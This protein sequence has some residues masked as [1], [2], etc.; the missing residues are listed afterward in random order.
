MNHIP[1]DSLTD[2]I[3]LSLLSRYHRVLSSPSHLLRESWLQFFNAFKQPDV[4]FLFLFD[5]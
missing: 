4:E 2:S 5:I 1:S 3:L